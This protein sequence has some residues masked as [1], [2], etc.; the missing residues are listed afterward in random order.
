MKDI[1]QL[2]LLQYS[3]GSLT[4]EKMAEVD[5]WLASH[6]DVLAE[7][8]EWQRV[9]AV[10]EE[11]QAMAM[12][13]TAWLRLEIR[14]GQI[15]Q[16]FSRGGEARMEPVLSVRGDIRPEKH[17]VNKQ[18]L[19]LS[20]PQVGADIQVICAR[21]NAYWIVLTSHILKGHMVKLRRKGEDYPIYSRKAGSDHLTIK[22]LSEDKYE[23]LFLDETVDIEIEEKE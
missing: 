15:E 7:V 19:R 16:F 22:G 13:G 4:P 3:E 21:G 20:L 6:P 11:G 17:E 8:M 23:L 12:P 2:T 5:L 14:Q 10:M 1:D 9:N 18:M